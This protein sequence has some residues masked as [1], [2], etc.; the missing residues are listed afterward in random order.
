MEALI[1]TAEHLGVL[2]A[3]PHHGNIMHDPAT[4]R[5][6][7]IDF[8]LVAANGAHPSNF[9]MTCGGADACNIKSDAD[10]LYQWK[11]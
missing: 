1:L 3:D 11:K 10:L 5:F 9:W 4:N 6:V 8:G 7:L 2:P